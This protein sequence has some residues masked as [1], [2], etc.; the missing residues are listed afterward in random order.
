MA[1]RSDIDHGFLLLI[2]GLV[3]WII[4]GAGHLNRHGSNL[5]H[6]PLPSTSSVSPTVAAAGARRVSTGRHIRLPIGPTAGR[7]SRSKTSPA[8][9]A[10]IRGLDRG[11]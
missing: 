4:P 11:Q 10:T 2:V 3:A 8:G 6:L 7:K 9:A 1:K 5:L